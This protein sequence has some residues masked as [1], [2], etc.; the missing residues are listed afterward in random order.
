MIDTLS[1]MK[2]LAAMDLIWR[3]LALI[4]GLSSRQNGMRR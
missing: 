1:V 2:K 4:R 3:D